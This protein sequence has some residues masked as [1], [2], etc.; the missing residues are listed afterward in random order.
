MESEARL[1]ERLRSGDESAFDVVVRRFQERVYQYAFHLV[2]DRDEAGDVAQETFI[3]A[4]AKLASFRGDSSLNTWL[5]RIASNLGI[6]ALRKRK[7]R[8]FIGLDQ[9]PALVA[10]GGPDQDLADAEI[11]RRVSAA[12]A[13]LP[14]RQRSIFVLRQYHQLSHR[15]IALVVGSSEGAV[16]AGYFHAVRKLQIALGDLTSEGA[17]AGAVAPDQETDG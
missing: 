14:P 16:R 12:V 9:A 5:Y 3:R 6:N 8:S 15:E 17:E 1:L 2:Q 7:L 11:R 10:P 4:Y 13:R